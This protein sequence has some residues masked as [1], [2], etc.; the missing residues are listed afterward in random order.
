MYRAINQLLC[1]EI[2][3]G[4]YNDCKG[5]VSRFNKALYGLK[6]SPQLW[7]KW[8]SSFFFE[9]LGFIHINADYSIFITKQGLE[10][11]VVSTFVDD[12]KIMGPRD[13]G[14]IARVKTEL[15]AAFEMVDIG[16]ISFYLGLKIERNREK[17]EIKL[18]QP[19]YIQKVLTKYYLDKAN[20]TNTPIKEV[21]LGAISPLK[22]LKLRKRDT[23]G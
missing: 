21:A 11:P 6:Q 22:S 18:S 5:I 16:L 12:I 17:K 7:Y 15:K 2:P 9:K 8:L 1:L 10:R 3:K 23:K 4:Y 14:V 19:A 13:S 20:T